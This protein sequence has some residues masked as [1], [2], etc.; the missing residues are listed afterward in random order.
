MEALKTKLN[1][2]LLLKPKVFGDDRGFFFES[3]NERTL[4]DYKIDYHFVQ[5]NHSR[6]R[7]NVLRGLH[8][9]IAQAQGKLVRAIVGEIFDVAVDIRRHSPTFGQWLGQ[10]L[11]AESKEMLWIPPGFAH[12]FVV[13]SEWAEVVYKA[14]DYYAPSLERSIRWDDPDLSIQWPL[15]GEAQLS[16]KDIQGQRFREV[17]V[18]DEISKL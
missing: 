17:E 9:Q 11:S 6:S 16:D 7:R 12:G 13:V 4:A 3:Y 1:G 14:T 8:Y 10:F 5:D 18:Y 2:V 15:T